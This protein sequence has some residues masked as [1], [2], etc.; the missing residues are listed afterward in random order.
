[1]AGFREGSANHDRQGSEPG[2]PPRLKSIH[3]QPPKKIAGARGAVSAT[4]YAR[5]S[6]VKGGLFVLV[7]ANA[8]SLN[9]L[10]IAKFLSVAC[11]RKTGRRYFNSPLVIRSAFK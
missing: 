5:R 10:T 3:N 2:Y 4:V 7:R 6:G 11:E 1:V 8:R 9:Q